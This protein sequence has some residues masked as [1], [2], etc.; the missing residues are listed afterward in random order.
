MPETA[1]TDLVGCRVPIQQ[2]PMGG[3][4]SPE[5][6]VAVATAGGVG[7]IAAMGLSPEQVVALSE[8]MRAQTDG[9]LAA[10]FLTADIDP[11]AVDAAASRLQIVDFFWRD[12]DAAL[13]RR[14]HAGGALVLWQVGS[15][16]EARAAVEAGADVVAVQGAEAGGHV[17]GRGALLPLLSAVLDEVPVPVLAA[18]GI[19][20]ARGV[21]AALAAG[22]SGVRVGTRFIASTESGAHPDYVAALLAAG[23]DSTEVTDGFAECPLCA[24]VPR[25]RV[26]SSAVEAVDRLAAEHVGSVERGGERVWLPRRAGLPPD[27]GVRG[28]VEAMA[29]YAGEGVGSIADV[30]PAA[31]IIKTLLP[32]DFRH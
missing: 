11:D 21:D 3:I 31:E 1:F 18:G 8:R 29:L 5:L 15:V 25:A 19:A 13:V 16:A 22:A 32:R 20:T 28:Q 10:N 6:A 14:A 23:P 26:L 2:A 30:L 4:S 24:S 7:T 17:R 9:V 27:R 12:P